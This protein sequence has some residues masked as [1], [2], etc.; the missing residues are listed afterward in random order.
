MKT[1]QKY[2]EGLFNTA[3]GIPLIGHIKGGIHY[4]SGDPEKGENS[5]KAATRTTGVIAGGTV[6][7]TVGGPVGAVVGGIA[8]GGAVDGITTG[9]DSAIH[10]EYR[11]YGQIASFTNMIRGEAKPGEYFDSFFGLTMDGIVG[12]GTGQAMN[13]YFI[14]K[15]KALYG[16]AEIAETTKAVG[17]NKSTFGN[18]GRINSQMF[19]SYIQGIQQIDILSW[20][21]KAK[22]FRD[23]AK[24]GKEAVI[25]VTETVKHVQERNLKKKQNSEN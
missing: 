21:R 15:G 8:C 6:G 9:V 24:Y 11:P 12:Y 18:Q 13:R 2:L 17:N 7:F 23:V 19:N 25:V 1:Q 5:I 16:G 14:T 4:V 20:A 3:D 10:K 22:Y